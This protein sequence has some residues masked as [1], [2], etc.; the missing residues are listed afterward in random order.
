[1]RRDRFRFGHLAQDGLR[2]IAEERRPATEQ[3]IKNRAK[4]IDIARHAL[5]FAFAT[6]L[7]RREIRGRSKHISG[8]RE[9]LRRVEL[10]R[11]AK[12][13]DARRTRS[14]E[15]DVRGLQVAMQHALL[16]G[17]VNGLSHR[18]EQRGGLARGQRIFASKISQ[19]AAIH[20]FHG[21]ERLPIVLARFVNRD[22]VRMPQPRGGGGFNLEPAAGVLTGKRAGDEKLHRND[23]SETA[24][25]RA[26][27]DAHAAASD[28]FEQIVIPDGL[29][30]FR[31][32]VLRAR[33]FQCATQR[34]KR[35]EPRPGPGRQRLRARW[36]EARH[37]SGRTG[38]ERKSSKLKAQSSKFKTRT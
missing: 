29:R 7:L 36:A 27:D 17:I 33:E 28:G 31:L 37:Q 18:P 9:A 34:A 3:L 19:G 8:E 13:A 10:S 35:A 20:Q 30:R 16:M 5:A 12:V 15:Q 1:M 21:E 38:W 26:I 32:G 11:E 23:P 4:R 22:D 24:L 2:R 25:T 6:R 14:I